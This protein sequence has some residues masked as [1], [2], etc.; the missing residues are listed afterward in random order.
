[1]G[2]VRQF[3]STNGPPQSRHPTSRPALVRS[4]GWT[5]G[6]P[7]RLRR[8]GGHPSPAIKS[9]GWRRREGVEPSEDLDDPQTGFEDQRRHRA[10]SF[11]KESNSTIPAVAQDR[12]RELPAVDRLLAH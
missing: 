3:F 12:L 2:V 8:Y 1:M 6:P 7:S 11:S 5:H 9:E 4:E 10:P